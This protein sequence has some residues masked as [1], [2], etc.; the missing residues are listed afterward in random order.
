MV[1]AVPSPAVA[2][3]LLLLFIQASLH[4]QSLV[5]RLLRTSR[6]LC[7][8]GGPGTEVAD[9][10]GRERDSHSTLPGALKTP[11]TRL[12]LAESVQQM[13]SDLTVATGWSASC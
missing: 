5:H 13:V 4:P 12:P 9:A 10:I 6:H 2:G 8:Q 3:G 1:P 7:R 11:L